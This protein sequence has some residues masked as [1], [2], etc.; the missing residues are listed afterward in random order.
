MIEIEVKWST[1]ISGIEDL[2]AQFTKA[3]NRKTYVDDNKLIFH[4]D[5]A[6]GKFEVL[7]IEPGLSIT[8]IDCEFLE[9]II[10]KRV[11]LPVNEF[12]SLHINLSLIPFLV[13]T[14]DRGAIDIGGSW[15]NAIFYYT[16]SKGVDM[17]ATIGGQLRT[18][19]IVYTRSWLASNYNLA[20]VPPEVR[21]ANE[22]MNDLPIQFSLDLDLH[23]LLVAHEMLFSESPEYISNL[24]FEGYARR[25]IALVANKL[26]A[27]PQEEARPDFNKILKILALKEKVSEHLEEPLPLLDVMAE[28]CSM[29]KST[30]VRLFRVLFKKNYLDFFGELRMQR[31]ADLLMQGMVVADVGNAVGYKNLGH[32]A[33]AFKDYYNE[34]PKTYKK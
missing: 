9:E 11:V 8:L 32:F 15:K 6:R 17:I 21:H 25:I 22:L 16:S 2:A 19:I 28:D 26:S 13:K 31:A 23:L 4:P 27:T 30:F 33:R 3:F 7:T 29:S 5:V 1:G 24:Y 10:F 20:H 34:S 12:H 14:H 18:V